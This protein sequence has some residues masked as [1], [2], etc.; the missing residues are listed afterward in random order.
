MRIH[1]IGHSNHRW[2]DFLALLKGHGVSWLI[3]VRSRPRSR[4]AYFSAPR[5]AEALAREGIAYRALGAALGGKPDDAAL[6]AAG[7]APGRDF[8]DF[9]K[10]RRTHIYREGIEA[11]L[12]MLE[13]APEGELCLMCAEEDPEYCHRTVLIAPDLIARGVEIVNIR[14][15]EP[16]P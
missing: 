10:V 7:R 9:D 1:T 16:R 6:Y 5:L 4:F 14:R 8:P 12:A 13:H 2:A 11:V 15:S 3:D